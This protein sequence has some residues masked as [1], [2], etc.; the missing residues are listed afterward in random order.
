MFKEEVA[1]SDRN[2]NGKGV[3]FQPHHPR[4]ISAAVLGS[5][6]EQE[7]LPSVSQACSATVREMRSLPRF[8]DN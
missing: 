6:T 8:I 2:Y 1:D 3:L 7:Q 4:T 5:N